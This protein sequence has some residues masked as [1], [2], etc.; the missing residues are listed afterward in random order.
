M[1]RNINEMNEKL[2]V[3]RNEYPGSD[4]EKEMELLLRY[5]AAVKGS[6]IKKLTD[7][8]RTTDIENIMV[9]IQDWLFTQG[10]DIQYWTIR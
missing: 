9:G 4:K 5:K 7:L 10:V 3:I 2:R 6:G 8:A 1:T